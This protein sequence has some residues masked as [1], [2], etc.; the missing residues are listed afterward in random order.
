MSF[1][2]D[3]YRYASCPAEALAFIAAAG[4][5]DATQKQA[6]CTLVSD[7][8]AFG[9]WTKMKAIYPF[10]GGTSTT[11]KF[12]LKDPRDLNAAFRLVF[13]GGITHS[14]NGIT[15]NGVNSYANTFLT[16]SISLST[17]SG[18]ISTYIRTNV[19]ESKYD[20]GATSS[21]TSDI[22]VISRWTG[23][24][25]YSNYGALTYPNASNS[26][27]RG[28]FTTNRN[29][30]TNTSG[31]KNGIKVIDT[32]QTASLPSNPFWIGALGNGVS[33]TDFS[34]KNYAFASIGDGLTDTEAANLYTAV[35]AYQT[36]LGRQV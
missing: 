9:I 33:G 10:V 16:P 30:I 17:N 36:T 26:D 34:S 31:Y 28:L 19:L 27:S 29:S 23:N 14:L 15:G 22:S 3:P 32:A 13:G 5:T 4:I 7:L 20:L 21:G 1:I 8:Q 11:H 24:L 35:Q 2:I 25:F 18:H 12:N 6:I